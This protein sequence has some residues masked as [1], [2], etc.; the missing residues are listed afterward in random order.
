MSTRG[1]PFEPIDTT[2]GQQ[3]APLHDPVVSEPQPASSQPT[4]SPHRRWIGAVLVA[5]TL[6]GLG[7]VLAVAMRRPADLAAFQRGD[8]LHQTGNDTKRIRK[9]ECGSDHTDDVVELFDVPDK[10]DPNSVVAELGYKCQAAALRELRHPAQ[11]KTQAYAFWHPK[12]SMD[13]ARKTGKAK[14]ICTVR[15]VGA[16]HQ[17]SLLK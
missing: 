3:A 11:E 16:T 8:C 7:T 2:T 13:A 17:G 1:W 12:A 15:L 4:F 10:A 5:V 9:V 14:V 6:L